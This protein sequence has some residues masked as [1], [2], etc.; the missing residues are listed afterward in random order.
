MRM[1]TG[2]LL[3]LWVAAP[4]LDAEQGRQRRGDNCVVD[5]LK[6]YYAEKLDKDY[7]TRFHANEM[8][9]ALYLGPLMREGEK[10]GLKSLA[11]LIRKKKLEIRELQGIVRS[12]LYGDSDEFRDRITELTEK[13]KDRTEAGYKILDS[14]YDAFDYTEASPAEEDFDVCLI[15]DRKAHLVVTKVLVDYMER[16]KLD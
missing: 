8:A 5:D 3:A 2:V 7:D 4:M 9:E 16:S 15:L 11:Q 10:E 12:H 1:V 6:E 14:I 13:Y